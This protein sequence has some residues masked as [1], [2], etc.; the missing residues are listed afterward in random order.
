MSFTPIN[1]EI[2][3]SVPTSQKANVWSRQERPNELKTV[4]TGSYI[5]LNVDQ[6]HVQ[7]WPHWLICF[8]LCRKLSLLTCLTLCCALCWIGFA[9]S[10]SGKERVRAALHSFSAPSAREL[11][12]L[13]VIQ[14]GNKKSSPSKLRD[15]LKST[16]ETTNTDR[17]S[18]FLVLCLYVSMYLCIYVSMYLCHSHPCSFIL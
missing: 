16:P 5:A 14:D 4:W 6:L 12:E 10:I 13:K 18:E 7:V 17:A 9:R 11:E 15:S 8:S 1:I 3:K 2:G